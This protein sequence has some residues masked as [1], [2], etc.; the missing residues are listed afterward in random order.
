MKILNLGGYDCILG[1]DWLESQGEMVCQWKDKWVQFVHEGQIVRLQGQVDQSDKEV[2]EV[3]CTQVLKWQASNEIWAAVVLTDTQEE[4]QQPLPPKIQ[5]LLAQYEV[6]FQ[7]KEGL[8][9]HRE[10][11]HAIHLLSDA[12]PVNSR[13]YQYSPLQK[14]E[15]E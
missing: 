10:Y 2:S 8:P 9:P 4:V 12:A 6:V 14:D 11:D 13:P 7:D 3:S 1:M 15:I 5:E